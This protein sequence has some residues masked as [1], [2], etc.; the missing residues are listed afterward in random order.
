[1]SVAFS[2]PSSVLPLLCN[3]SSLVLMIYFV[4]TQA[5]MVQASSF[6]WFGGE[7][8]SNNDRNIEK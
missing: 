1:M 5:K 2:G 3:G 8:L 6:D 7:E 4:L